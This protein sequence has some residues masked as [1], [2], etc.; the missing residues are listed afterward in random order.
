MQ[1]FSKEYIV[2]LCN[3]I[4]SL[5]NE[6]GV[7]LTLDNS[8]GYNAVEEIVGVYKKRE[9]II[10]ELNNIIDSEFGKNYISDNQ[11]HWRNLIQPIVEQDKLQLQEL[12]KRVKNI[13]TKLRNLIK[14][15]SLLIYTKDKFYEY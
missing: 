5:T 15:K 3:E 11:E 9:Q 2:K 1:K 13:N 10:F 7:F 8:N 4:K 12:E 14:Q 6:I